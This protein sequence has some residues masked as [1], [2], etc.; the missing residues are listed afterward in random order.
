M[1]KLLAC[2]VL[3]LVG[4]GLGAWW[5]LQQGFYR[6]GALAGQEGELRVPPQ[7]GAAS[8]TWQVTPK[9]ALFHFEAG[10][11][12]LV[13]AVHG[14]PGQPPQQPWRMAQVPGSPLRM[15]F[16]HQRGCGLSTRVVDRLHED[17]TYARMQAVEGELGLGAQVADIER[18]RRILGE[19]KLV[20]AGHSFGA[21]IAALYA[22]EFPQRVRA[23]VFM[24]PANLLKM[25]LEGDDL[26]ARV[27]QRLPAERQAA[28]ASY[29]QGYF[30]F[31][32]LLAMD[33]RQLSRFYG[34]FAPFYGEA[35]G[36][37]L[38]AAAEGMGGG[39]SVLGAYLSM[40][41]RHD[42]TRAMERV[43]APV[44]VLHGNKDLV[45]EADAREFAR[46]FPDSRVENVDGAGHFLPDD[47]PDVA[48][49]LIAG[50]LSR[51]PR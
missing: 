37:P 22:A 2:G 33:E 13:L 40:G 31:P 3:L 24:A 29:L 25:P 15:L 45:P 7:A 46:P 47:R 49:A 9:V 28:Y 8:D 34:G 44:L 18:I 51:V 26:F 42:W 27:G 32:A 38:P 21:V 16:Y 6:P 36:M 10:T 35:S 41:R 12:P 14:G 30:D 19:E 1:K 4:L 43:T 17:G 20:L 11:G 48:A 5:W 50:F 39:F 23:L